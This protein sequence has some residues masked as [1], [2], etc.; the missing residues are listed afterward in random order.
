[1]DFADT[2]ENRVGKAVHALSSEVDELDA[3]TRDKEAVSLLSNDYPTIADQARKL[4]LIL[5]RIPISFQTAA[6]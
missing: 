5:K 2:L 4:N 3:L 1:M 6:E